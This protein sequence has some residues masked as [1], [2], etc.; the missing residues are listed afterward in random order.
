[1]LVPKFVIFQIQVKRIG[2]MRSEKER[3]EK[4]I[5]SNHV[6]SR[7]LSYN[8]FLFGKDRRRKKNPSKGPREYSKRNGELG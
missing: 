2:V 5:V 3:E 8:K 1:M 6:V 7:L 4:K